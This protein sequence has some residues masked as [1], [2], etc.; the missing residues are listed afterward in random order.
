MVEYPVSIY[1]YWSNTDIF[2]ISVYRTVLALYIYFWSENFSHSACHT[3]NS[4]E[5]RKQLLYQFP[6]LIPTSFFLTYRIAIKFSVHTIIVLFFKSMSKY[7]I[8]ILQPAT[9]SRSLA[10]VSQRTFSTSNNVFTWTCLINPVFA[11]KFFKFLLMYVYV[12]F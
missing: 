1:R 6:Q 11:A 5:G 12:R 9:R 2:G 10:L 7:E 3:C 4:S 8:S